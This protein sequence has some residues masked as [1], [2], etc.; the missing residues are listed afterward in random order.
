MPTI[1]SAADPLTGLHG[2]QEINVIMGKNGSGKSSLLRS[3]DL[4]FQANPT[5]GT[6]KYVTPERGGNLTYDGNIDSAMSSNPSWIKDVRRKNRSD[7]FR[8][9]S[10]REFRS[11]ETLILRQIEQNP[12]VRQNLGY[13]FQSTIDQI[14]S[15][16]D[17]IQIER[18][19]EAGFKIKTKG[20]SGYRNELETL[21]SG[22]AE[23][24]SLAIEII[25]YV[26]QAEA[27][28]DTEKFNVLLL[29]EPDVHLHPDLQERLVNLI[30]SSVKS[31][32]VVV[33]IATHSTSILSA[34]SKFDNVAVG[35]M[36]SQNR[37][38]SFKP[39]TEIMKTVLPVFGAHPLSNVFNTKP[40]L[41]VEGED[42]ERI[43]QQAVRS[44]KGRV[45]VW[46]CVAGDVQSLDAY[47][48]EVEA[49]C[50][51]VYDKPM[52]YSLRDRDDAPY[53]IKNK[54]IVQRM[55]L[56]CRAAENLLLSDDV[57]ASLGTGWGIMQSAIEKWI[58]DNPAHKQAADMQ[59]FKAGGYDRR[60]ANVK[61]LR[62]LFMERA[63]TQ[64]PWEV[65]VGQSIARLAT[66]G[67]TNGEN[68]L[69]DFLGR[70]IVGALIERV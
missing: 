13:S 44:S 52:A 39:V 67:G 50:A 57:L 42:D 51:A 9:V 14:N 48:D 19:D 59:A 47:E 60:D 24:I 30:H 46:P 15:L 11:L 27:R 64:K 65:A 36:D 28:K 3:I 41:L 34:L 20:D 8:Q 68:S 17:Y 38:A 40:I 61:S 55:R 7:N 29:D 6:A 2:L 5:V 62:N 18:A 45:S 70:K 37:A 69:R 16:L 25:S 53:E 54:A 1:L 12:E 58:S 32:R 33:I 63:G 56:N 4:A 49:I 10:V 21:S 31:G 43:W 35:F 22:E 23:L 26:H 66:H